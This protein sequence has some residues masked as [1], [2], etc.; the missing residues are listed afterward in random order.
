MINIAV[1]G[2]G[3][4]GSGVVE[5]IDING[6]SIAE[7]LDEEVNV[8]YVLDLKKFPGDSI[9]EKLVDDFNIILEDSE[10]EIIVETMGGIEPAYTFAKKALLAGKSVVT[11]NKELVADHGAELIEIAREKNVNF[12]FGASVG[13]GIPIIRPMNQALTADKIEEITG[14]LNG[15]T[16]YILTMMSEEGLEFETALKNAQDM[17]YAER[18]P[19]ADVDGFDACRKIAILTSLA[20]GKQVDFEDIH[21][22]GI[23][24][25]SSRDFK[26]ANA[27]GARIKLL[28]S[29]MRDDKGDVYAIVAPAMIKED[30]PLYGVRDVFNSIL[31]KGNVA[32]DLMF[33]GSGA[34]KLPT[35]SAVVADVIDIAKHPGKN[36][37]M[38]WDK[39]KL[40]LADIKQFK[41]RFF[42][43]VSQDDK[44]MDQIK[45]LFGDVEI[46][47]LESKTDEFA[48]ITS[49]ITEEEFK[50][51]CEQIYNVKNYIRVRY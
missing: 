40:Q 4:I 10:V 37:K 14:I 30:N 22:E 19:S 35:A 51:K 13:G 5:V 17:G 1:L 27:L 36:I 39:E 26:Y 25:I 20:Y 23:R 3:T 2:Y 29:S 32:G 49:S 42:V 48:F 18:D 34:G 38:I 45:S 9:M 11:S 12:L 7:K 41:H 21:T 15:T 46:V 28:A 6:D 24:N 44:V 47:R 31:V 8:K 43:R 33:Y 16:N 50:T